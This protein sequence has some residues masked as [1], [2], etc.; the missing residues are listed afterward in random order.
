MDDAKKAKA[1]C[2]H[3]QRLFP[4]KACDNFG[5][6]LRECGMDR[7]KAAKEYLRRHSGDREMNLMGREYT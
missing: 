4:G 6:V 1:R 3:C 7:A 5:C 2:P